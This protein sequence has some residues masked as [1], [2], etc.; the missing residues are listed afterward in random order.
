MD[1]KIDL[2]VCP[3]MLDEIMARL[4]TINGWLHDADLGS[5]TLYGVEAGIKGLAEPE[6]SGQR[7]LFLKGKHLEEYCAEHGDQGEPALYQ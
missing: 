1:E 7:P 2:R 3:L 4:M 6:C 5:A